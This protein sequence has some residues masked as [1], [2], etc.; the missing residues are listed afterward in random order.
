[1]LSNLEVL[2]ILPQNGQTD[3]KGRL[4]RRDLVDTMG[5]PFYV[6]G[7]IEYDFIRISS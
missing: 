1:M 4:V 7:F 6:V 2:S 5:F 3:L